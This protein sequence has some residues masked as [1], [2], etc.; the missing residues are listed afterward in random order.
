MITAQLPDGTS[1]QFPDDTP[2]SVIQSVVRKQLGVG[3]PSAPRP[4][5]P[6]TTGIGRTVADQ[7]VQG[8]TFGFGDEVSDAIGAGVAKL[9]GMATGNN[10]SSLSQLYNEARA[11]TSQRLPAQF[12]ENPLTS[13]AS[14]VGGAAL[15]GGAGLRYLATKAPA[16][17]G[18]LEAYAQA[19]PY[20]T[21]IG[22]GISSG[23]LY[24]AGTSTGGIKE[25]IPDA[26]LGGVGGAVAGPLGTYVGRNAIAPLV[27]KIGSTAPVQSALSKIGDFAQKP[28]QNVNP[29]LSG[30]ESQ[31]LKTDMNPN[32]LKLKDE[33]FTKT[34]GQRLQDAGLQRL[35]ND[36]RAG[37]LTKG[38]ERTILEADRVQ[39]REFHTYIDN[40]AKGIDKGTDP[41]V[42]IEGVTDVLK[43][44][45][46]AMKKGVNSAYEI[47]RE[48]KGV[49]IGSQDIREG[50]W[51]NIAATR[52]EQAYDISQMP[53]A[54]A[55]IKRLATY[56]KLRP[57][58]PISAVKL[59]ELENWRK[60]ATNAISSTQDPTE[61]RFLGQ[62]VRGYDNFME[63]TA[64]DAVDLGDAQAINAFKDAVGK[65]RE[66]GQLFERNKIVQEII[67]GE[68]SVDDTVKS[69][70]GTGSIKGKKEMAN[71]F[72]AIVKAAGEESDNV[73][74]DLRQAFTLNLFKKSING[75]E[76]NNPSVER[77][78]PAKLA[79]EMENLF[80][81]Q[82]D[83][84]EKLYGKDVVQEG[85]K[86]IK[87]LK[88]IS[89][90]QAGVRNASGSGEWLGRFLNAPGIKRIPGVGLVGQAV[91]AQQAHQ[92][93][94]Q[95]N[96]SLHDFLKESNKPVST[97]WST[98][99]PISTQSINKENK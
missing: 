90:S 80:I 55:V 64:S 40:L 41:N 82:R 29:V 5:D 43:G 87:E 92:G 28:V 33:I 8:L 88:L 35:E 77:I 49:K 60:Q 13:I 38:A 18:A 21:A 20:K 2:Q 36:A 10:D 58:S 7:G 97:I 70:I 32:L 81:H 11:N 65:R 22:A 83:F 99:A 44:N 94:A 62:M 75:F 93:A 45:A 37:T 69:L 14:Q 91:E 84:A 52:R 25:R 96:K 76:P 31:V 63:E 17:A 86:G 73:Q 30:A 47:A 53:K 23:A 39:N 51:S 85:L 6:R 98:V 24:G 56:S 15:T 46:K 42:L 50:L 9:Y 61:K 3:T 16:V 54:K 34:G 79:T 89:T 71:N 12:D 57:E 26:L 4:A 19:N 48:G 95:V 27:N 74:S 67:G 68:K 1:L 66:Y 59:G 72:D 78:S